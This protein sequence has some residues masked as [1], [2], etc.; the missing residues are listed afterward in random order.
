MTEPIHDLDESYVH[1]SNEDGHVGE[2]MG[3]T[4]TLLLEDNGPN[5][6]RR[7]LDLV[8]LTCGGAG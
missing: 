3:I 2:Q 8:V 6:S 5:V 7:V 4:E 1:L